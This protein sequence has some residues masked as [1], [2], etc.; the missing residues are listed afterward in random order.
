MSSSKKKETTRATTTT[1]PTNP[2]WVTGGVQNLANQITGLSGQDPSSYFAPTSS[3]QNA[4]FAGAANLG[5]QP[6]LSWLQGLGGGQ[7]PNP[8]PQVMPTSA[9]PYTGTPIG[10]PPDVPGKSLTPNANP[11]VMPASAGPTGKPSTMDTGP[12]VMP[13]SAGPTDQRQGMSTSPTSP[14][15]PTGANPGTAASGGMG[16]YDLAG[17]LGFQGATGGPNL[18]GSTGYNATGYQAAGPAQINGYTAAQAQAA[19]AQ[20]ANAGQASTYNP[21]TY[22]AQTGTAQT[23]NPTTGQAVLGQAA[24]AGQAQTYNPALID[25]AQAAQMGRAQIGP[26]GQASSRDF[27]SVNLDNYLNAGLGDLIDATRADYEAS[28]AAG[29]ARASAAA[30]ANGGARNSNNAIRAG[31]LDAEQQRAMNSGLA[32][33]R[34][35]AYNTAAG[36]AQSDLDRRA[37]VSMANAGFQTQGALAQGNIDAQRYQQMAGQQFNAL[38]ANQNAANTAGQFNA[39]AQNDFSLQNAGFQ[40]QAN[41]AN[42]SAQNQFGLA[43][44]DALNQAGQYNAGQQNAMTQTNLGYQNQAALNN[45]NAQNAASQW[46]AGAANDFAL[47]NAGFNQQANLQ[48]AGFQQQTNLANA[49]AQNDALSQLLG[50]QGQS[51][52]DYAGRQDAAGQFG[53]NAQNQASQFGANAWNNASQFNAG[54][55]DASLNRLLSGGQFL[56]NLGAQMSADN[57][58]NIGLQADLGAQQREIDRQQRAAPLDLLQLQTQLFSGLPLGLFNGQTSNTN[59]TTTQSGSSMDWGRLLGAGLSFIPGAGPVAGILGGVGT[60]ISDPRMKSNVQPLGMA[61]PSGD[62][63]YQFNYK[64]DPSGQSFIGPMANEVAQ[65]NPQAVGMGPGGVATVD[66]NALGIPSP[67][68]QAQAGPGGILGAAQKFAQAY[69]DGAPAEDPLAG[70]SGGT[71]DLWRQQMMENQ[72]RMGNAPQPRA[73]PSRGLFGRKGG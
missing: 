14:S 67:Q 7:A 65:T 30:A 64:G 58:A 44:M 55:Q 35:N 40:Q 24:S 68:Q 62:P 51:A 69:N 46:N 6:T 9:G 25:P 3:L 61:A 59:S 22:N 52:L 15:A 21:T 19:N 47:Q 2:A 33:T 57:R 10:A 23:Y 20:A 32:D 48:N 8:G 73:L 31:V 42:Q 54:Q 18:A 60:G 5:N 53:A 38:Q 26:V 12:Q 29:L 16:L 56:G 45:A 4:A 37:Q 11:Q 1:T 71:Q 49:G 13:G 70:W 63:L 43:N 66:Y 17:L 39:G 34:Y 72:R 27:T 41:L 50:L 28:N 36:L